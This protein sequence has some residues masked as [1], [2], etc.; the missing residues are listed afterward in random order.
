MKKIIALLLV[1]AMTAAASVAGTIAYLQDTDS[2]VNVMTVGNVYIEQH[3]YQRAEGV[4]HTNTAATP[5]D[6]D[7]LVPYVQGQMIYPAVPKNNAATDYTAEPTDLFYW[8]EYVTADGAG[9][10]L[11]DDNK[12]ANVMDKMVFVENTGRS[13]AYYRTVIAFECPDGMEFSQGP[14]KQFMMNINGHSLFTW[15]EIDDVEIN[16]IRHLVMIATY[17]AVLEPK[18]IS[19]PS[20][21]QVVMTDKCG[22]EDVAKLGDVY[23]IMVLSQAVQTEG[24]ADAKS[25]LDTAF[26]VADEANIK[27]WFADTVVPTRVEAGTADLNTGTKYGDYVE[28]GEAVIYTDYNVTTTGGGLDI[29]GTA[30]FSNGSVTTNSTSTSGRHVFYVAAREGEADGHLTINGGEFIFSP[31]NLTRKGSYLYADGGTIIVNGGTFHKPSTRTDHPPIKATNGGS[32]TIY[33]GTFAFDPSAFVADGY[34]AVESG[35][36]WTVSA[37]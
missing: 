9:N 11:W 34:Q 13:D 24:F 25:A 2:D 16:G 14:D 6:D 5:A 22:N 33:G 37:K 26:G 20:L 10:G 18:E 1:V 12:L 29:R 7:D 28:M 15:E 19:R 30:V 23:D 3:E 17:N 27:T 36:W 31:S 4:A 21:L 35:G 32:V 8:G